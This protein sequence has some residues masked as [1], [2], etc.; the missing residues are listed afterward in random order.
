[1]QKFLMGLL[2][3]TG[4][5]VLAKAQVP[6]DE[7]HGLQKVLENLYDQMM[8][9]CSQLIGVAQGIAGFAAAWYIAV[10]VWHHIANAEPIDFFPLFRPFVIGFCILIFPLVLNLINGILQPTVSATDAIVQNTNQAM[11]AILDAQKGQL[12]NPPQGDPT[13]ADDD[14]MRWYQYTHPDG[15]A[16]PTVSTNP[17]GDAFASFSISYLIRKVVGWILDLLFKTAVLCIDTIRTFKLI[18]LA[19]LGPLVFGLSIFDGFQ[20]TL[21]H[22]LARYV[23]VFMWLPVANIFGAII[24]KI[25]LNMA[26]LQA[27][28]GSTDPFFGDTNTAYLIFLLI[29][30]V[31][32]FSVPSIAGYIIQVGGH[33]LFSRT[34]SIASTAVS[35]YTSTVMRELSATIASFRKSKDSG[36]GTNNTNRA[37]SNGNGAS[38]ADYKTKKITGET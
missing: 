22:W 7:F 15:P 1:M 35:A 31:G 37:G 28:G 27:A 29:A 25:Q 36:S 5:P 9:L 30:I 32:Y 38:G 26:Q 4:I 20:H 14:P 18:V 2:C 6:T 12:S 21:K 11:N 24:A 8:P 19:I 3:L 16:G 23:N 34:S 13:K 17:I 10:R 33:A